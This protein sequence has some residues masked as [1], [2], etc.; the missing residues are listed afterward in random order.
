MQHGRRH[1]DATAFGGPNG[2]AEQVKQHLMQ[3][4]RIA[5]HLRP[6]LAQGLNHEFQSPL[7]GQG[8][9]R[10]A[11]KPTSCLITG[12]TES[13]GPCMSYMLMRTCE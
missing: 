13:T 10:L 9:H 12:F 6:I 3:P 8:R 5:Q 1:P 2:V 11:G 4:V 7:L